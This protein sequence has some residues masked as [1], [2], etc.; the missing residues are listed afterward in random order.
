LIPCPRS[1]PFVCICDYQ[2]LVQEEHKDLAR[3]DAQLA[4]I[5]V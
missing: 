1:I 4:K 3:E 5:L 2:R